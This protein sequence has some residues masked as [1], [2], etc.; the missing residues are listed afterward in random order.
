[1]NI[2][3][4]Q[5]KSSTNSKIYYIPHFHSQILLSKLHLIFILEIPTPSID[6]I[7]DRTITLN[8]DEPPPELL[9]EPPRNITQY[10]VTLT[11][12]DGGPSVSVFVPAQAGIS[13]EVT[14]LKP[15][16]TY[17]IEVLPI[18]ATEGQG[19]ATFDMGIAL[20]IQTSMY[21]IVS[22]TIAQP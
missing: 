15:E 19:E 11:P 3:T 18:I 14:G 13:Y 12:Q 1:M 21:R 6:D 7:G 9:S 8:W 20:S 16:T 2:F 4:Y 5:I 17:D 22:S 10:A